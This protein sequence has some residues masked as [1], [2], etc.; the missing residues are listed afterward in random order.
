M[1]DEEIIFLKNQKGKDTLLLGASRYNLNVTNPTSR[2]TLWRCINRS[3]CS[4]SVTINQERNRVLRSSQ[5][6][7]AID[8]KKQEVF[9]AM[10]A[11][12]K[13]VCED[14]GSVQSLYEKHTDPIKASNS[15]YIDVLPDFKNVEDGLYKLRKRHLECNKISFSK[16]SEVQVP[17][18][19]ANNF[20]LCDDDME[21][22]ILIFCSP[23]ARK[24]IQNGDSDFYLGD[25][26][27]NTA[28]PPF[29]QLYTLHLD[30]G[31]NDKTN[32]VVP[33]IYGLLPN[34]SQRTYVRFF[35]LLTTRL[36]I[37]M[38]T[39]KC[40]FELAVINAVQQVYPEV[41]VKGCFFHYQKAITKKAEQLG[42]LDL[43]ECKK[44]IRLIRN[45]PLLPENHIKN[46]WLTIL[47]NAPDFEQFR[48][49]KNYFEKQWLSKISTVLLS[50]SDDKHRTTNLLEGWHRRVAVK[51]PKN[52]NFCQFLYN[53][54]KESIRYDY[55]MKNNLFYSVLKN[56]RKSDIAFDR[57]YAKYLKS[58]HDNEITDLQMIKKIIHLR[59]SLNSDGN[60]DSS[61]QSAKLT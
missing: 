46:C 13:D 39:F 9:K 61:D 37:H 49:F 6:T 26:T 22:K 41:Q 15:S 52:P 2:S 14:L 17:K 58:L 18:I 4:A 53:I 54:R 51:I 23:T 24:F 8:P 27:F 34:K 16:L 25:G 56:R 55:K 29:Y 50:C 59:F 47:N 42:V 5:H 48:M 19:L 43:K 10:V 45:L 30:L 33:V 7:C 57:K 38:K 21:E 3:E 35:E 11:L 44:V 20:L 1:S 60:S 36:N 32:N 31:S 40:D 28:P 12:K